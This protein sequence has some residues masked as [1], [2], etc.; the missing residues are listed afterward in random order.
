MHL[1]RNP[2]YMGRNWVHKNGMV[3]TKRFIIFNNKM[4]SPSSV[5][6]GFSTLTS[7]DILGMGQD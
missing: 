5:M 1:D 4:I 6:P 2:G 3:C 7:L